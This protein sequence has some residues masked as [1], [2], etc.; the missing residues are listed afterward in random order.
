MEPALKFIQAKSL[1]DFAQHLG[2]LTIFV[3]LVGDLSLGTRF[4]CVH[5]IGTFAALAHAAGGFHA[6]HTEGEVLHVPDNQPHTICGE[7]GPLTH[8]DVGHGLR[9][10]RCA[11]S[12]RLAP[13]AG[14]GLLVLH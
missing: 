10:A 3:E 4:F 14:V 8:G 7:L 6:G 11:R 9:L 2:Q 12:A 5:A 13:A 1:D